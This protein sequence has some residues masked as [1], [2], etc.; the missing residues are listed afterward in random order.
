MNKLNGLDPVVYRE[1]T[2]GKIISNGINGIARRA[3]VSFLT[4]RSISSNPVIEST[5]AK[6]I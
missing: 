3:N 2:K 1:I 4:P 6:P 5:A